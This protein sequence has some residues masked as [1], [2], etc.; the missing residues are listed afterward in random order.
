LTTEHFDNFVEIAGIELIVIDAET[1][2]RQ[3]R[4][5]LRR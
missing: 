2:L 4:T 5:L 3:L 1:R